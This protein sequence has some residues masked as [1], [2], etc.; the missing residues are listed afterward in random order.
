MRAI[1]GNSSGGICAFTVAGTR[2]FSESGQPYWRFV[3][4]RGGYHY[5]SLIRK[6]KRKLRVFF[7]GMNIG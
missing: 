6:T 1:C 4:I 5:P 3:N 2:T 7:R